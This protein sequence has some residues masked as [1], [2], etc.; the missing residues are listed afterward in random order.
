METS[1][2]FGTIVL[3]AI[4]IIYLT[5]KSKKTKNSSWKGELIKKRDITDEDNENHVY[6]L[7]FRINNGKKV[8]VSVSEEIYNKSQVGDKFEKIKGDYIPK[9]I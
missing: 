5:I 6:R 7:I 1:E 2:V 4:V 9:K 8:K 3:I